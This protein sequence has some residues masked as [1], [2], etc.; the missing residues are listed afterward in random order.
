MAEVVDVEVVEE[1]M[2]E[3][4]LQAQRDFSA[5]FD[6]EPTDTSADR[7]EP[8]EEGDDAGGEGADDAGKKKPDEESKEKPEPV[9]E[10]VQVKKSDFDKLMALVPQVDTL[11]TKT[12]QQIDNAF[13]KMGGY[14]RVL[15][16]LQAKTPAGGKV[17]VSKEKIMELW[18]EYPGLGE[19]MA[20]TLE[21]GVASLTGTG[22]A[23][24][25]PEEIDKRASKIV[26]DRELKHLNGAYKNW[27]EIVGSVDDKGSPL[28]P[29]NPFRKW[30]G[31]Q[32]QSYQDDL[33]ATD[34]PADL[35]RAIDRF[36]T[37]EAMQSIAPPPAPPPPP[38]PKK[39]AKDEKAKVDKLG[40][41]LQPRGD[42][43]APG[44]HRMTAEE[45]FAAG[46]AEG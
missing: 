15:K 37:W 5:G 39:D 40:E 16:E 38:P 28:D 21:S 35:L 44:G 24:A 41:A 19:I 31:K 20:A 32:D 2:S 17:E 11:T 18:K 36:K 22:P 46:Y 13:S 33:A 14:D 3:E 6:D 10:V 30:L 25:D 26:Y 8:K 9:D 23:A 43:G 34:S 7:K 1:G 42:G 12:K 45:Q 27:R 29:N 4:E